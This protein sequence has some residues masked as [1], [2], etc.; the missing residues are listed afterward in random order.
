[1]ILEGYIFRRMKKQSPLRK[2]LKNLSRCCVVILAV[3]MGVVF[4]EKLDKFL[5][6]VGALLCAPIAFTMPTL[7]HLKLVAK[8]PKERLID[9][10]IILVS[11]FILVMCTIQSLESWNTDVTQVV[12][13]D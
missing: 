4:A 11:F 8:T 1:M 2:W 13:Q 9:M 10:A 3:V 6:L 7:C 12:T 5:S